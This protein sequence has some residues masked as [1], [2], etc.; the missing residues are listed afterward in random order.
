MSASASASASKYLQETGVCNLLSSFFTDLLGQN[1]LPS[2]PYPELLRRIRMMEGRRQED[3]N[4]K[5]GSPPDLSLP[6]SLGV[7]CL[8]EDPAVW[9][10][11]Q[12]L[13]GVDPSAVASLRSVQQAAERCL[14]AGSMSAAGKGHR[15]S[16][17]VATLGDSV[18][19]GRLLGPSLLWG[20]L[21]Q[22]VE[23]NVEAAHF[24]R[25]VDYFAAVV[26]AD[27]HMAAGAGEHHESSQVG[28]ILLQSVTIS[29]P[30]R[31]KGQQDMVRVWTPQDLSH[32]QD[33]FVREI[34]AGIP[35]NAEISMD[36]FFAPC[37]DE[38]SNMHSLAAFYR[39]HR[40]YTLHY[41]SHVGVKSFTRYPMRCLTRGIFFSKDEAQAYTSVYT[42]Q[43]STIASAIISEHQ[44]L[45]QNVMS[46][47]KSG[48]LVEAFASALR[49]ALLVSGD[50][51]KNDSLLRD[52]ARVCGGAASEFRS[53]RYRCQTILGL[54][55]LL[56]R[57]TDGSQPF[58]WWREQLR[59]EVWL[60]RSQLAREHLRADTFSDIMVLAPWVEQRLSLREHAD[61]PT[62]PDYLLGGCDGATSDFVLRLTDV[63]VWA[64]AVYLSLAHDA[65]QMCSHTH[66]LARER[67]EEDLG[68]LDSPSPPPALIT[69]LSW[70]MKLKAEEAEKDALSP[71]RD[72]APKKMLNTGL[73]GF[74][75]IRSGHGTTQHTQGQGVTHEVTPELADLSLNLPDP[76]PV[77]VKATTLKTLQLSYIPESVAVEG[78]LFQYVIDHRLDSYPM[79]TLLNICLGPVP[80]TPFA[81]W[82]NSLAPLALQD[83]LGCHSPGCAEGL[84]SPSTEMQCSSEPGA[85]VADSWAVWRL[86]GGSE[87]EPEACGSW[88]AIATVA[89]AAA[90]WRLVD[91]VP[92]FPPIPSVPADSFINI[93]LGC[94]ICGSTLLGLTA[95]RYD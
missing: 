54:A 31:R 65:A 88:P 56:N 53:F 90:F 25:A 18:W 72:K 11:P 3:Q 14:A 39:I 92:H 94:G 32:S 4:D 12:V 36:L 58:K 42:E 26:L 57:A 40:T 81:S 37:R 75:G 44:W 15:V 38:N 68:I 46:N 85:K 1:T 27:A 9:G 91:Q 35:I 6:T 76:L 33:M 66:V 50:D 70:I 69:A 82:A 22:S 80:L 63:E 24:E 10:L 89:S 93:E 47:M 77:S 5:K 71:A 2:F 23:V 19:S 55:A 13:R 17:W 74:F 29:T 48:D 16:V 79:R 87:H 62:V 45:R 78:C 51:D 59:S 8:K 30:A 43:S 73:G 67:Q 28:D 83:C 86:P 84:I 20:P 52:I 64:H 60:W 21:Q 7:C 34:K 41:R 49:A 61:V 95:E